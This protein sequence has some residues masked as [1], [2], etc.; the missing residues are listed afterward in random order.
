MDMIESTHVVKSANLVEDKRGIK[1]GFDGA[2]PA[3]QKSFQVVGQIF[4]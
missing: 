3:I 1:I 4:Q 2:M